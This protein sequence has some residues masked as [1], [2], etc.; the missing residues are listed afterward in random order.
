MRPQAVHGDCTPQRESVASGIPDTFP[1]KTH[2]KPARQFHSRNTSTILFV[3][4]LVIEIV[5]PL[6]LPAA[7]T[8]PLKIAVNPWT[9][10][11][12]DA[13]IAKI[14]LQ[15]KLG[16]SVELVEIDE[17]AQFPALAK[18]D[19]SATMEVWPS[20]HAA[21]RT[22]Y[23]EQ[24]N[25]VEDLGP[26]GVVGKIGWYVPAYMLDREPS[27]ATWEGLKAHTDLFKT[28]AS[29]N[30]GQLLEGDPS[31]TY[32]DQQIITA[33]GLNLKIVQAG[34]ESALI[35][36]IDDAY[37]HRDPLLFYFWTPHSIHGKYQLSEVQL[38]P[39][40]HDCT[41]CG[42]PA[43]VLFK[44]ASSKLA[45]IAPAAHRFLQN[46]NLTDADQ[47][48]LMAEVDLNGKTPEAAARAWLD[49]NEAKW[50]LWL[51][52]RPVAEPAIPAPA[53]AWAAQYLYVLDKDTNGVFLNAN[54]RFVESLQPL[55][56]EIQS[57][58]N[59]TGHDDFYFY[60]PELARKF[61]ADDARVLAAGAPFTTI[62][63]N[64]PVGGVR[65]FVSV[66]K[67][68][69][70]DEHDHIIG[71]RAIWHSHP[72]LDIRRT[73]ANVR[74][75]FPADTEMFRLEQTAALG[76]PAP[77]Q[78]ITFPHIATDGQVIVTIQTTNAHTYFRM[79]AE[80]PVTIGALLSI[81]G[82]WS[83]L[84]QN[85][86]AA[87]QAG[88]QRINLEQLSSGSPLRFNIDIRD[89]QLSPDRA[90]AELQSLSSNGVTFVI[91]P[92]SSAELRVLKPFAD[93]HGM[94]LAS[95]SSTASS[96]SLANDNLFRFCP[97]DTYEAAAIVALMKADGIDALIPI[98][99]DDAGNQGL[100][101]SIARIFPT[102]GGLVYP[103]VKYAADE[104]NF[105]AI[106]N[107]LSRQVTAALATNPGK[108][109][110]YLAGFDE[111]AQVFTA[112]RT[113]SVLSSVTWYGS[114][115]VVQSQPLAADVPA[116]QFAAEHDY[117]CPTFGLDGRYRNL[118]E[119]VVTLLK[120]RTGN[121]VDAFTLAAYD[122]LQIAAATYNAAGNDA[123]FDR[124]KQTF[125]NVSNHYLGTTGPTALNDAG[126]RA[127]GA[128][129]FWALKAGANGYVWFQ[130]GWYQPLPNGTAIVTRVP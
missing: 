43:D 85:C 5:S 126:D 75:S 93:A 103:G 119:P 121:D 25:T 22:T 101:D 40:A 86:R 96:L 70:R 130:S 95:P 67:V 113:D 14:L 54:S 118:W 41:G 128:F 61:R 24:N 83:T 60:A 35:A 42:Y 109:A 81:T 56:P 47:I 20:G 49:Q 55:F 66:T 99:R 108:A 89:T 58:T 31:W 59:L 106:A 48:S 115:G 111:V 2:M 30:Q 17:F 76:S 116:A 114:D 9:G 124:L 44:A 104:I 72:Q 123:A 62:E 77:W 100:H 3:L 13:Q 16:Y 26:L 120:T 91:G 102:Q 71:L 4:L 39:F 82:D 29:G 80:Q 64:E 73:P 98:W 52:A 68:P 38:P 10:S 28:S 32:H 12:L 112:A 19:L 63:A 88:L 18:G 11:A 15:E 125:V 36:A 37:N 51:Q 33:L 117:F 78:P 107:A 45:Q 8:P 92:Q 6:E 57:S 34:S 21:D 79:A 74:L 1:A 84:G 94:I 23:I 122:A 69:L 105:A 50:S 90:L 27:L 127:G 129:D 110:I 97:D 46:M 7:T 53:N 87:L 65:T